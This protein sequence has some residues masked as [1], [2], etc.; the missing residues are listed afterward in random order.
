MR[1]VPALAFF[2]LALAGCL[3]V[4]SPDGALRCS[5]VPKRACPEG[6]YCFAGDNTCWRYGHYPDLGVVTPPVLGQDF[7]FS[8]PIE[9]DMSAG[10]D[11]GVPD[12]LVGNDDLLQTD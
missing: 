6:F 12:D 1:W 8:I 10:L 4:D 9:D 2:A 5:D 11:G 7:D 3:G